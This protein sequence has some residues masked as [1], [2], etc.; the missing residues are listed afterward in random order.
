[1]ILACWVARPLLCQYLIEN[2]HEMLNFQLIMFRTLSQ[3]F[4]GPFF[5]RLYLFLSFY[6]LSYFHVSFFSL[7]LRVLQTDIGDIY[8]CPPSNGSSACMLYLNIKRFLFLCNRL[9]YFI[10]DSI[11]TFSFKTR[12]HKGQFTTCLSRKICLQSI[13]SQ[14]T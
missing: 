1:M 6:A 7:E 11:L 14:T 2:R 10:I 5:L 3:G 13:H 4:G 8:H 12:R 9:T